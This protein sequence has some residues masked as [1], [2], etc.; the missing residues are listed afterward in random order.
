MRKALAGGA[1]KAEDF[2]DAISNLER[3]LARGV[4]DYHAWDEVKDLFELRRRLVETERRREIDLRLYMSAEQAYNY[5]R[6][7]AN[8]VANN[9]KDRKLLS[10][11]QHEF[12]VA[13]N[14]GG[15]MPKVD[16]ENVI[17]A[18]SVDTE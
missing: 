5:M 15:G 4:Q 13:T 17:E 11:I 10:K 12:A 8:A 3:I 2:N 18:R 16:E 14:F 6:D 9:V 1:A 7:L